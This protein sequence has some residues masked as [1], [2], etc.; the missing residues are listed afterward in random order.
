V[1][2]RRSYLKKKRG[3][4]NEEVHHPK[5]KKLTS[6]EIGAK[7]PLR[8]EGMKGKGGKPIILCVSKKKT[9]GR[10]GKKRGDTTKKKNFH[11]HLFVAFHGKEHL[12]LEQPSKR[13]EFQP[14]SMRGDHRPGRLEERETALQRKTPL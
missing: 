11:L 7:R 9:K 10:E 14:S 2:R 5:K 3:R 12:N 1:L 4:G 13:K 6:G 8:N